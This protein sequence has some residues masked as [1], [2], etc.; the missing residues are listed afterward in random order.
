MLES[1]QVGGPTCARRSAKDCPPS[2]SVR[3]TSVFTNMP[4]RSSSAASPRPAT[5]VPIATSGVP[6]SRASSTDSAACTTMNGDAAWA[7]ATSSIRDR[8]SH[9]S[10]TYAL[11]RRW[12]RRRDADGPTAGRAGREVRQA[13]TSSRRPVARSPSPGR[14]RC[15]GPRAATARSRRTARRAAPNRGPLPDCGPRRP[16]SRRAR[17]GPSRPRRPRCG[18]A[19]GRVRTRGRTTRKL[20]HGPG[21]RR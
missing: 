11:H 4:I 9:R 2:I 17:A 3:R 12:M 13:R 6:L 5:G 14:P 18:A 10:R 7:C 19:P 21:F 20:L 8:R 16:S 1:G 15:R